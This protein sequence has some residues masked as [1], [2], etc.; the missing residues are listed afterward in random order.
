MKQNIINA[1][2]LLNSLKG[3]HIYISS[4]IV[5]EIYVTLL[6]YSL[7]PHQIEDTVDQ[8]LSF[9]NLSVITME[10]IRSSWKIMQRYRFSYWDSMI[11]A[12]ALESNC[13]VLYTEDIQDHQMI[14]SIL[15]ISN[16][17]R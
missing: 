3:F 4:K 7:T 12:T 15:R 5:N 14:E 16:P 17:F 8:I 10:T 13:T 6:K 2:Q 11:V 1:L 9:S